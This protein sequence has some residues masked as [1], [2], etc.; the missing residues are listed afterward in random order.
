MK[1]K[2]NNKVDANQPELVALWRTLGCVV[3]PVTAE[4]DAGFD[5][6]VCYNG[7][8]EL[9]EIKDGNKPPSKRKLTDGELVRKAELEGVGCAL[10]II[11]T[12]D[13][14]MEL[15]YSMR[16]RQ[17]PPQTTQKGYETLSA[18]PGEENWTISDSSME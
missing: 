4:P 11:E 6:I 16:N 12:E 17:P 14:A 8:V 2:Y 18:E 7:C 13:Q 15:F 9:V 10:N 5:V 3:I 1:R